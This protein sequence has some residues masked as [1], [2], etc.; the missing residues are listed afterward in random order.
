LAD[1]ALGS[2]VQPFP[3]VTTVGAALRCSTAPAN[4]SHAGGAAA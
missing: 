2:S 4:Y 1:A 3:A